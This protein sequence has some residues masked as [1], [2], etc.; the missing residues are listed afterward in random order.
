MKIRIAACLLFSGMIIAACNDEPVATNTAQELPHELTKVEKGEVLYKQY[1][2]TCHKLNID[3]M[4]PALKDAIVRWD[5]D[6][7]R[8]KSFIRNAGAA[9]A[10]GDP[11]AKE[12][13][14][15]WKTNMT[16]FPDLTDDDLNNLIAWMQQ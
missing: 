12:L 16:S 9:T 10:A 4:G 5:N 3:V 15:K 14:G 8:L 1:C 7:V 13:Y 11:R 2:Q 6:T